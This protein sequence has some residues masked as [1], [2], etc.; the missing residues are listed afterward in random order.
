MR[1]SSC[2]ALISQMRPR[3]SSKSAVVHRTQSEKIALLLLALAVS[4]LKPTPSCG[5]LAAPSWR[6]LSRH[7]RPTFYTPLQSSRIDPLETPVPQSRKQLRKKKLKT[8][9]R[10]L[11]VEMWKHNEL[12][13]LEPV[14]QAVS[15]ACKQITRIVQR[16]NTDD[17]YGAALGADGNPLEGTNVQGEVQQKLDV[18]CN[19]IM[20]RAFCGSSCNIASIASE[21]EDEPRCCSDVMVRYPQEGLCVLPLLTVFCRKILHLQSGITLLCSTRWMVPRTS[22][23]PYPSELFLESTGPRIL[24]TLTRIRFYRMGLHWLLRAI[25][26]TRKCYFVKGSHLPSFLMLIRSPCS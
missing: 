13:G 17:F 12:R 1:S 25:V 5:L 16:A 18:L 14:L 3:C 9:S 11:E 15:E 2:F 22:T 6:R 7:G 21:E 19:T 8:F 24:R 23:L 4:S 20:T 26:F 10:F